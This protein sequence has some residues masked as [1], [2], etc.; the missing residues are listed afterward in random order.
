MNGWLEISGDVRKPVP[1]HPKRPI[2]GLATSR[3]EVSGTRFWGLMKELCSTPQTFFTN[4]YVHNYCPLCFMTASGK[5][6]TPPSMKLSC[7]DQLEAACDSSLLQVLEL[8]QIEWVVGVGKYA[9]QRAKKAVK[10]YQSQVAIGSIAH[11]SP[12]NPAA[13]RGWSALASR[14]LAELGVL[15]LITCSSE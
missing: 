15:D 13:N 10:L 3:N 12:I 2:L 1:E 6:V 7:K 5:N 4:C 11:P 9:E 14:Q 8:L